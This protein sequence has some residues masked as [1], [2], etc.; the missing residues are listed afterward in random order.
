MKN[1]YVTLSMLVFCFTSCKKDIKTE[2][3]S[4]KVT[5]SVK[6]EEPIAEPPLD[7]A[8]QMKAWAEYARPGNPHK[9]MADET[10]TW[11]CDM[12]FWMEPNGKPE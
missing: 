2:T 8:A 7:S 6:T 12:T 4:T 10:G 11:N 3:E 5:D 1:L 9:M